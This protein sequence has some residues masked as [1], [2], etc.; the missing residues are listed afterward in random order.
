MDIKELTYSQIMKFKRC[1]KQY[2]YAYNQKLSS[3]FFSAPLQLGSFVHELLDAFYTASMD[4][5]TYE[6]AVGMVFEKSTSYFAEKTEGLFDEELQKFIDIQEQ[7][8]GIVVRYIDFY[9]SDFQNFD[10]VAV[11]E[12][13]RVPIL[14]LEGKESGAYLNGKFDLIMEDKFGILY[15]GEHKTTALGIQTRLADLELDEQCSYYSWA[16]RNSLRDEGQIIDVTGVIYNVLRKKEPT[17]PRLLKK[18]GLSKAKDIDTTYDLYLQAIQFNGLNIADYQDMLNMLKL[19]G[20]T[21]YGREIVKRSNQELLNTGNDLYE[22]L[23]YMKNTSTFYRNRCSL[24]SRDCS[25]KALCIAEIKGYDTEEIL[26]HFEIRKTVN[27]ELQDLEKPESS[28]D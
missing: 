6:G 27:P 20:N 7:A 19:K 1:P 17:V 11:E 16:L 13:F 10:I 24:C 28:V 9:K 26:K 25:Y 4:G 14:D 5:L 22:T 12:Q 2:D 21:F 23:M 8:E 3:K 15:L 18:G